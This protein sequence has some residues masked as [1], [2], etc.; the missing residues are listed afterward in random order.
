MS[1]PAGQKRGI[2]RWIFLGCAGCGGLTL[3][4][5]AGCAGFLYFVY[6]GTEEIAAVGAQYLLR[7]PEVRSAYGEDVA[8][9]RSWMN[10]RVNLTNDTG[11]AYF[12]YEV[13]GGRNSGRGEVW[14]AKS[15]GRWTA[16]GARVRPSNGSSSDTEVGTVPPARPF[17]E[18]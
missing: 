4:A 14:L 9:T 7:A 16:T 15:Q 8:V 13:R 10:S 1:D 11:T 6:K 17:G 12:T 2:G 3:L 18:D 5:A